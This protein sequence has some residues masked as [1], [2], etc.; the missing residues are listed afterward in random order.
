MPNGDFESLLDRS[1]DEITEPKNYPVGTWRVR[2]VSNVSFKKD[3]NDRDVAMFAI[4]GVEPQEDVDPDAL[5]EA[6]D[7]YEGVRLFVRRTLETKSDFFQ[8]KKLLETFGVDTKGK[9]LK[10]AGGDVKGNEALAYIGERTYTK[11]NE[12]HVINEAKQFSPLE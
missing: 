1:A 6:G 7:D 11:D 2:A 4:V 9:T 10:E 8:L 5:D 3:N 12:L